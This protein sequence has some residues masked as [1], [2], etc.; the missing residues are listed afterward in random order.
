[1]IQTIHSR[2]ASDRKSRSSLTVGNGIEY[3][4]ISTDLEPGQ[5]AVA[6]ITADQNWF[7]L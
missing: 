2:E 7:L 3:R 1:M 4:N 6:V 5:N